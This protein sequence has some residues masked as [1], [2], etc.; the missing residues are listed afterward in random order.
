MPQLQRVA[1]GLLSDTS[2]ERTNFIKALLEAWG[3]S[4]LRDETFSVYETDLK[5]FDLSDLHDLELLIRQLRVLDPNIVIM[6]LALGRLEGKHVESLSE[7][8]WM[9][10]A[11][12]LRL[13]RALHKEIPHARIITYS[14]MQYSKAVFLAAGLGAFDFVHIT[15]EQ[16][17]WDQFLASVKVAIE[18]LY[19][20]HVKAFVLM[21]FQDRFNDIYTYGIKATCEKLNIECE[22]VDEVIYTRDILRKIYECMRKADLIIADLTTRNPNVFYEVGYAHALGKTVILLASDTRNIPFDLRGD[23]VVIYGKVKGSEI[24]TL[25]SRLEEILNEIVKAQLCSRYPLMRFDTTDITY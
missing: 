24:K 3:P 15:H 20:S 7:E 12:R 6:H 18:D 1:I 9:A 21:P 8:E 19:R 14:R 11:P 4:F 13:I 10:E 5:D 22:R 23:P 17:S 25:S 16:G 2:R